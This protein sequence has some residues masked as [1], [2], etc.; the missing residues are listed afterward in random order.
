[1]NGLNA[2]VSKMAVNSS[3][4]RLAT[5]LALIPGLL[6][7]SAF[8]A[9]GDGRLPLHGQV[10]EAPLAD[11]GEAAYTAAVESVMAGFEEAS[12]RRLQPA[13]RR[14]AG[15]KVYTNSGPGLHTPLE[16]TR[17]VIAGLRARGFANDE[18][19]IIDLR[20]PL[21]RD[22]GYLPPLSRFSEGPYFDGVRV[23]SLEGD[24]PVGEPWVYES[25]L[26]QEFTNPL[27]RELL[28]RPDA[29]DPI[30]SRKSYLPAELLDGV[31]FWINLPMVVDQYAVGLSGATVN[32]TLHNAT[33]QTRFFSSPVN[34]P[35][36]VAEIA[37]IPE[38]QDN[39]AC[40]IM[41]LQAYQF[42]GGP[43]FNAHYTLSE[44]RLWLA[45]DPL[46]LD[47]LMLRRVNAARRALR[48]PLLPHVLPFLEYAAG[49]RLGFPF[50]EQAVIHQPVS[51]VAND[52]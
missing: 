24:A 38:L 43:V 39:W 41:T 20:A 47:A 33:N 4:G 15:I 28:R 10:W 52:G 16:L 34:A 50:A 42:I 46:I 21:L 27:S 44:P 8:W 37:A 17:A 30:L 2:I 35:V 49:L 6:H 19:F 1:M 26:P 48:F 13:T 45:A 22:V 5:F 25:P 9:G 7:G 12:G 29:V 32:A 51:T 40:T 31:D 18:M 3:L 23:F 14:R 11:F 36:A